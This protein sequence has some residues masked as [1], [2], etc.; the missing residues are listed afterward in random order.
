[1]RARNREATAYTK[2]ML[3]L[4]E[5][6]HGLLVKLA[7]KGNRSL[8]YECI[9]RLRASITLDRLLELE[10]P[11]ERLRE[12]EKLRLRLKDLRMVED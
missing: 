10:N 2:L 8:N 1:M 7:R 4:P 6:L 5:K 12:L 3:R 9:L 11:N